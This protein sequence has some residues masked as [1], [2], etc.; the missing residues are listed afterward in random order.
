M[1]VI[2]QSH[3]VVNTSRSSRPFAHGLFGPPARPAALDWP[4]WTDASRWTTFQPSEA[5]RAANAEAW[6]RR[7]AE[8]EDEDMELR[9]VEAA[10]AADCYG[11]GL[12]RRDVAETLLFGHHAER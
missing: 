8:M 12:I 5:D 4:L 9:A 6:E 7:L 11:I 10:Y 3:T 1:S 2:P